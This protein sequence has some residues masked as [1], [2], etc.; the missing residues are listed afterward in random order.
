MSDLETPTSALLKLK[1]AASP[2]AAEQCFL[3]ESVEG[4]E[5]LGRWSLLGCGP[6]RVISV[7]D[8][9]HHSVRKQPYH[10]ASWR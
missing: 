3:L 10:V 4:G 8:A 9:E 2:L 5:R 7:G 1:S 6:D